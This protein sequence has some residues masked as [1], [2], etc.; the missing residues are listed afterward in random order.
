M[1]RHD[2]PDLIAA[3]RRLAEAAEQYVNRSP[4]VTRIQ[5]ERAAL[6]DAIAHAQLVLS[7]HRLP[8]VENPDRA[9]R[10]PASDGQPLLEEQ[11]KRSQ[12]MLGQLERGLRPLSDELE[13]LKASAE[14]AQALVA[15]ALAKAAARE[16]QPA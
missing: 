10:K 6:L 8:N 4:K 1:K 7:V 9:A 3:F 15:T 13:R 11:L 5:A 16:E 14:K 12:A 2:E